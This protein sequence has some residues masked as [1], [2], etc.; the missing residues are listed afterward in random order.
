[1]CVLDNRAPA[2]IHTEKELQLS[3][4]GDESPG[5]LTPLPVWTSGPCGHTQLGTGTKML[6]RT[7]ARTQNAAFMVPFISLIR[8]T[9]FSLRV[10]TSTRS[11][12]ESDSSWEQHRGASAHHAGKKKKK[13]MALPIS[14]R[15]VKQIQN[16]SVA[17][18]ENPIRVYVHAER[19]GIDEG[20]V[21][22]ELHRKDDSAS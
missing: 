17:E 2:R 20:R 7:H 6:P 21:E 1:M 8:D 9:S 3:C 13:K 11:H 14:P 18:V 10:T 4:P 15:Q 5:H 16:A 19:V 22:A 12:G